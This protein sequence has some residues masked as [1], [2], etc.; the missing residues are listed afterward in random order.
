MRNLEGSREGTLVGP[1]ERLIMSLKPTD[2]VPHQRR[3]VV[4]SGWCAA[5]NPRKG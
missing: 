3:A 5:P 4:V 1:V 2:P